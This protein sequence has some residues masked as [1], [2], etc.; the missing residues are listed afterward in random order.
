[1]PLTVTFDRLGRILI[2]EHLR[3]AVGLT[4]HVVIVGSVNRVEIWDRERY[5]TYSQ[6]IETKIETLAESLPHE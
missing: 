4:K 2:P 3:L 5:H 1:M 6:D